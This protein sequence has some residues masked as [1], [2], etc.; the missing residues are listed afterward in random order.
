MLI[1]VKVHVYHGAKEQLES[2]TMYNAVKLG[3]L[4]RYIFR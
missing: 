3:Y 4:A 1:Q 2:A